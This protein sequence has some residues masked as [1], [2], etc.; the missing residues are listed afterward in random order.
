MCVWWG[1]DG[2][3]GGFLRVHCYNYQDSNC[4]CCLAQLPQDIPLGYAKEKVATNG[5]QEE[6]VYKAYSIILLPCKM[7]GVSEPFSFT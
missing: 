6:K 4:S 5:S 7:T 3:N 1:G 2:M